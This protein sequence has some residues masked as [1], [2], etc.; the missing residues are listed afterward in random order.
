M[1]S[2]GSRIFRFTDYTNSGTL[3]VD[4]DVFV[5]HLRHP[6]FHQ[7]GHDRHRRGQEPD[8]DQHHAE[9]ECRADH[10][11]RRQH[12]PGPG[13]SDQPQRRQRRSQ[14]DGGHRGR[15]DRSLGHG[16]GGLSVGFHSDAVPFTLEPPWDGNVASGVTL[17]VRGGEFGGVQNSAKLVLGASMRTT[18]RS[19]W[20]ASAP[21]TTPRST[22]ERTR[23]PTTGRSI[24][25]R[26]TP[27]RAASMACPGSTLANASTGS[28]HP[29]RGHV[30]PAD[31]D[32]CRRGQR[33]ERQDGDPDPQLHADGR[34]HVRWRGR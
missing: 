17:R 5:G 29:R 13:R 23:S 10:G 33:R 21:S 27:G 22:S 12:G 3:N 16:H 24:P 7:Y 31:P 18:G 26:A 32:E 30:D 2:G 11:R 14:R 1:A 25:W 6:D 19:I 34:Q 4:T 15:F 20:T 9:P 28:L 8:D